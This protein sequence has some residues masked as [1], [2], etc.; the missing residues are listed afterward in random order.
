[1]KSFFWNVVVTAALPL[2]FIASIL[3]SRKRDTYVWGSRPL[4]SFSYWAQALRATGVPS[5]TIMQ[6]RYAI[7][8]PEDFDRYFISFAPAWLPH[9]ARMGIG[10]CA[11]LIFV[12][13]RAKVLHHPFDGFALNASVYWRLEAHLLRIAGVRTVALPYGADGY[14]YSRMIDISMRHG[15]LASYPALARQEASIGAR[16]AYWCRHADVVIPGFMIDGIG[17]WDVLLNTIFAIDTERWSA[18]SV[19]NDHDGINGVVRVMHTPN[20]RGFKGTEFLLEAVSELQSEGLKVEL[21]L[22][23]RVPNET[24]RATMQEVDILAE[25]FIGQ[26]YALSGIEGMASGLPVMANLDHEAFTTVFRRYGFLDECPILSSPPERLK[27][28]LRALVSRPDLRRELGQAGR[29]YVEKYHSFDTARYMF[30]SVYKHLEGC[31]DVDL[32]NLFHPL[33]SAF[34]KATPRVSHPLVRNRLPD[35]ETF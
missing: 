24:V 7:N 19:Y 13:R 27:M 31:P 33:K 11:A 15:L 23:E 26:G 3:P 28:N 16:V 25:Q 30:T 1:M 18:K 35:L 22:L 6:D 21:V 14:V 20:H 17:R 5:I 4:I 32:M 34:N 10:T 12:L 29:L 8:R 2:F 9:L